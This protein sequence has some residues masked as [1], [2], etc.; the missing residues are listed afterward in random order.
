M[1]VDEVDRERLTPIAG[2]DGHQGVLLEV[3]PRR[4]SD[5]GEMLAA[6]QVARHDPFLL[7]LEHLQDPVN[8]GALLRTAEAAGVDGVLYPERGSAPLSGAAVKA[9]AGASEHVRLAPL[10][11]LGAALEETA[12]LGA[13]GWWPRTRTR[14]IW[15]GTRT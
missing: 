15:R 12:D 10:D 5:L 7:V 1:P 6:A 11:S 4:W 13:S 2:F 14:R 3:E 8:V 9:S